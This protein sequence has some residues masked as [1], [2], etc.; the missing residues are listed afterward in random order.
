MEDLSLSLSWFDPL[1]PTKGVGCWSLRIHEI[2][3]KT[4]CL[5]VVVFLNLCL[6]SFPQQKDTCSLLH[7]Q[8][9]ASL[10]YYLFVLVVVVVVLPRRQQLVNS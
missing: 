3:T 1:Q 9:S 4:N 10:L 2:L 5:S 8:C 6:F 7:Q